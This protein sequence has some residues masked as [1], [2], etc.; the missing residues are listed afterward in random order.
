MDIVVG[1]A[2]L[3]ATVVP[4]GRTAAGLPVGAQVVGRRHA[5]AL[6]IAV[7]GVVGALSGG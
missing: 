1:M 6:T 5:D 4:V 2:V 3:P 7:A